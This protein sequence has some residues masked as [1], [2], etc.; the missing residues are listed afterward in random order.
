MKFFSLGEEGADKETRI[1]LANV[2]LHLITTCPP[3]TPETVDD[4][5]R[6]HVI[7]YVAETAAD[8]YTP[9]STEALFEI[10]LDAMKDVYQIE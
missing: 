7:A 6:A 5:L 2:A 1:A 10:V 4:V 9:E 8:I 3:W